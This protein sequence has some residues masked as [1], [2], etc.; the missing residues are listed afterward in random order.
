VSATFSDWLSSQMERVGIRS[1]RRLAIEAGLDEEKVLDW[2]LGRR[3]PSPSDVDRLARFFRVPA[4]EAQTLRVQ[5]EQLLALSRG[6][7]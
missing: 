1:G 5:T 7:R 6:N 4:G 3:V 2:T